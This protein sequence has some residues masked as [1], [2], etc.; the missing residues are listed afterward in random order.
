MSIMCVVHS[1][2][3][4]YLTVVAVPFALGLM[5]KPTLVTLPCV[6]LLSGLLAA[7]ADGVADAAT[8]STGQR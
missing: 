1:A 2:L 3:S 8:G 6:L 5:A 7:R 4:R